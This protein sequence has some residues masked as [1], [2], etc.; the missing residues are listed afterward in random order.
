MSNPNSKI[1]N[2]KS[3]VILIT[4][5]SQ[6]IGAAIAK[7]FAR[8]IKGCRIALVARTAKKL[9]TVQRACGRHS[10]SAVSFACDVS[11]DK[12]VATLKRAVTKEF[13]A[14]DVLVNNAG[15]FS[16]APLL[17]FSV[18]EFDRMI[19][20]NLRSVFLMSRAFVPGMVKAKRGD[21]FNMS[22]VAGLVAYPGGTGYSAAKFGVTGL[23]KVMRAELKDKG[24]R[25]CTVYP[26][27]T[28][29]PSWDG[30]DIPAERMMPAED[31]AQA[32][33]DVYRMSRRTVVE[34]IVLRPQL[35]DL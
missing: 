19:A 4:G 29:S 30:V 20:T 3:P 8:E 11:D 21:V 24:V 17:K 16:G 31:V 27:A 25:V 2:R 1:R 10:A 14:V 26:G 23:S 33:Y 34:E 22:S 6:G 15:S 13:G 35:G 12:A 32:F 18:A 28:M 7:T 9:A 5:A